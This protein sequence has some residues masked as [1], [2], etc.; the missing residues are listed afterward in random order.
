[1]SELNCMR[2]QRRGQAALVLLIGVF[3]IG[4]SA[5]L[6]AESLADPTRPALSHGITTVASSAPAALR[7]E[8]IMQRLEC[9]LAIVDGKVVRIGDRIGNAVIE[10]ITN[11]AV[12]YSR[13]GRSEVAYLA[14]TTLQ[15]RRNAAPYEELP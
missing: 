14:R 6:H 3:V 12:R 4:T 10:D 7:V 9:R 2:K 1:M 15:V 11:D 13:G 8:A 5:A